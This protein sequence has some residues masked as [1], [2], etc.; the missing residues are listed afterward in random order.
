MAL[1]A[2]PERLNHKIPQVQAVVK[3]KSEERNNIIL[4]SSYSIVRLLY[5]QIEARSDYLEISII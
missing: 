1:E 3:Q 4:A 5:H 2:S